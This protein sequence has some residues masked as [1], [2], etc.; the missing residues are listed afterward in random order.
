[1]TRPGQP[2]GSIKPIAL[3]LARTIMKLAGWRMEVN[4]P[5]TPR[6][7]ICVAP[8]TSNWDF[9]VGELAIRSAGMTAGFLMKSTWFFFPLGPLFRA[10][11]GIPV[12]RSKPANDIEAAA[13]SAMEALH[14]DDR[15]HV[16][17]VVVSEFARKPRLAIAVTPEGTRKPNPH[18]HRGLLV[19]AQEAQVPI[20]LAYIDYARRVACLDRIFQPT[21]DFDADMQAIKTYYVGKASAARYPKKFTT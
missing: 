7:L 2:G 16:T 15:R 14:P 8:H 9:I 12:H 3:L 1:M 17:Q 13:E 5:S 4:I 18:W 11:G 21:G 19:M 10:I 6:C 20:V